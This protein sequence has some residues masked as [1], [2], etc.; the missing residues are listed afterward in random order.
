MKLIAS[1]HFKRATDGIRTHDLL[2]TN[3]LLY[4][5]SYGGISVFNEQDTN[6][7]KR[8]FYASLFLLFLFLLQLPNCFISS[9]HDCFAL[10]QLKHSLDIVVK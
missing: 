2:I 4:Q 8:F 9:L 5:L 6:I 1:P 7:R 10:H 3:E